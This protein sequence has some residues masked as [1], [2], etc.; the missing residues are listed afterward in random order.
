M[1]IRKELLSAIIFAALF[2]FFLP[3]V[4]W[5]G[6]GGVNW[7]S[8]SATNVAS[9]TSGSF[10]QNEVAKGAVIKDGS[11]YKLW[12]TGKNASG[13]YQIGYATSNDGSTWSK[14]GAPVLTPGSAGSWDSVQVGTPSVVKDGSVYKMWYSGTNNASGT[15]VRNSQIGYATSNDG[16]SWSRSSSS[17]PVLSLGASGAWDSYNIFLPAVV[18]VNDTDYRMWF[19]GVN[20]TSTS[21]PGI[22][23]A[24]STDG[25][26]WTKYKNPDVSGTPYNDST[27]V[28][29]PGNAGSWKAQRAYGATV[30]QDG[31]YFRMWFSGLETDSC[32]GK[33]I[34]FAN[35]QDGKRWWGEYQ[36]NPVIFSGSSGQFNDCQSDQ[37]MVVKNGTKQ[38][39]MWFVG[40][41]SSNVTTIGMTKSSTYESSS[42]SVNFAHIASINSPGG[43]GILTAMSVE[44]VNPVDISVLKVEGGGYAHTYFVNEFYNDQGTQYLAYSEAKS[45]INTGDYTFTT[46]ATNG[47]T[48][49]KTLTYSSDIWLNVP[50]DGSGTDKL[51]RSVTNSSGAQDTASQVYTGSATPTFKWRPC[52]GD[53][54]YYRVSVSNWKNTAAWYNSSWVRG[55]DA[56]SG[57]LSVTVPA[58]VLKLNT[59]YHWTIQ[60]SDQIDTAT[61]SLKNVAAHRSNSS[62]YDLYTGT[63]G[64]GDFI[65][66][67]GVQV[68]SVR[69]YTGGNGS[70]AFAYVTNIAPWNIDKTA[71]VYDFRVAKPDGSNFYSFNINP[72]SNG[73]AFSTSFGDFAYLKRQNG[74]PAN[75]TYTFYIYD[76]DN[77]SYGETQTKSFTDNATVPRVYQMEPYDNDYIKS[78]T[79]TMTWKSRGADYWYRVRINDFAGNR[80]VYSSDYIAGAADGTG[81]SVTIPKGTL[82]ARAPYFWYVE[83]IDK[84][85]MAATN[86]R[87]YSRSTTFTT[88]FDSGY[89]GDESMIS[90]GSNN[91]KL[92]AVFTDYDA[93]GNG[94]WIYTTSWSRITDWIPKEIAAFG[95]TL[96]ASF[97]QYSS[98][99]GVYKYNGSGTSWSRISDWIPQTGMK[100]WGSDKL[101][102]VFSDYSDGNGLWSYNGAGGS[103]TRLTDWLPSYFSTWASR[104]KIVATFSDEI[105]GSGKGIY[106]YDGTSWNRLTEWISW[107]YTAYGANTG[108]L[109]VKFDNYGTS[110]NGIWSY[111]GTG[112]TRITDWV[113][114]RT[115][116][117]GA[118]SSKNLAAYFSNYSD[119]G[120][121]SYNGTSWSRL[122]DWVPEGIGRSGDDLIAIFSNY[123]SSGNGTWKYGGSVPSWARITDWI[124]NRGATMGSGAA[125]TFTNYGSGNGIWKYDGANWTKITDWLPANQ[126]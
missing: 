63:K 105:Y 101:A 123:G 45:A 83:V 122:T 89:E 14:H 73:D 113:P 44:G 56:V 19:T 67:S 94:V 119:N 91:S 97:N 55:S 15:S 62:N 115:E 82:K 1:K 27:P 118:G 108:V 84:S 57:F 23:Y 78:T 112:W 52:L 7:Y 6:G 126:Q 85:S 86:N 22:G 61:G 34:G 33:R 64:T 79:P 43:K 93:S 90:W 72:N 31:S 51:E 103:W 69:S 38:Y 75:G 125:V 49:T 53:A 17:T 11:T 74:I 65:K 59:P 39:E 120:V 102:A 2:L 60:V 3:G 99:N 29:W 48:A 66:D 50:A 117:W 88:G 36:G 40:T 21:N 26:T 35:S 106:S 8:A 68:E 98:G 30:I 114:E 54:L 58:D 28:V 87:N 24:T 4:I 16:I 76:K 70:N 71:T 25:I 81:M 9:G 100:G 109:A 20:A 92:A 41:N 116:S 104:G 80:P 111:N 18:K 13:T 95:D 37:P 124:P 12:Y 5:A 77:H 10:D 121:W 32:G 42:L 110:G 107:D 47:V 46:T 96:A